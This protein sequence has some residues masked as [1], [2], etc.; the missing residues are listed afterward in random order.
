MT[1]VESVVTYYLKQSSSMSP[2]SAPTTNPPPSSWT[3][4][5]PSYSS[6][7]TSTLYTVVCTTFSNGDFDYSAVSKSSAYEAAKEAYNRAVAASNEARAVSQYFWTSQSGS[8]AGVHVTQT[9]KTDFLANHE[10]GNLLA[11]SDGIAVRDG[12]TELATFGAD[13]IVIGDTGSSY[14]SINTNNINMM[15]ADSKNLFNVKSVNVTRTYSASHT[16]EAGETSRPS[17]TFRIPYGNTYTVSVKVNNSQLSPS[18]YTVVEEQYGAI[19][20]ITIALKYSS[21]VVAGDRVYFD[22]SSTGCVGRY[23]VGMRRSGSS[24]SSGDWSTVI[25]FGNTAQGNSSLA[26]G[27]NTD[28]KADR[29]FAQG[30]SSS[31]RGENSSAFGVGTIAYGN[32]DISV[33]R[34]NSYR[35]GQSFVVGN[36]EDDDA[37]SNAFVVAWDGGVEFALDSAAAS[38]TID[39]DLYAAIT[40]LGWGNEVIV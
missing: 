12:L 20:D 17:Y 10:G 3:T 40:A 15:S 37:R 8:D 38:G 21:S 39:G 26:I 11:T 6:G 16:V 14:I 32:E 2:P 22:V 31:A 19:V 4:T 1:D 33:G 9:T 5:E 18:A 24:I 28:A 23:D 7:E 13:G 34:Y 29:S 35:T 25:G 30:D 36:G 27:G